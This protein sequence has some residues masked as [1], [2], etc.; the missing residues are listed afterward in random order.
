MKKSKAF[1]EAQIAVLG[2]D[3]PVSVK[4]K[5]L[6]VLMWEEEFAKM[7]EEYQ[8]KKG[9]EKCHDLKAE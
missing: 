2:A 8:E 9:A 4:T 7:T 3:M 5:V 6:E 1:R